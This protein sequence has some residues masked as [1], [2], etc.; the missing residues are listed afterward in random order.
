[1][2]CRPPLLR[3]LERLALKEPRVSLSRR[4]ASSVAVLVLFAC[5]DAPVPGDSSPRIESFTASSAELRVGDPIELLPRFTG[6]PARIEPDVGPVVSGARIPVGPFPS[7]MLF[8][9]VVGDGGHEV[10]RELRLPLV[11]RHRLQ[12]LTP[13]DN[14]RAD[15]GAAVL[16]DGR[17]LV[18]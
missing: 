1:L 8:T 18:F 11:Y 12:P 15:H 16:A 6:A 13:S 10:R 4:V 2:V 5:G 7:G 9:L 3:V 14:A 17:V